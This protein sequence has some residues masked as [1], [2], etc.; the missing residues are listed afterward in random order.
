MLALET[1]PYFRDLDWDTL[2]SFYYVAR[3][4]SMSRA[5]PFLGLDQPSL[6]RRMRK[7]QKHLGYPLLFRHYNG[8]GLTRKGEELL[9]I[10]EN[11]FI[12]MKSF[13]SHPY[14]GQHEK[15]KRKVRIASHHDL[16]TYVLNRFILDYSQKRPDLIFEVIGADHALD[17]ILQ[18]VDIA[19]QPYDPTKEREDADWQI[20]Q[21]PFFT[22]EKKLYASREYLEEYGEPQ[23]V[24]DLKNHRLIAPSI[25]E[26]WPFDDTAWMLES[27]MYQEGERKGDKRKKRD[28]VF[29]SNSLECLFEAAR[30][31]RGII[32]AYDKLATVKSANL[33]NILPDLTIKERQQHFVYPEYLKDDEDIKGIKA[34]LRERMAGLG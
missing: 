15:R 2:K 1:S 10:V 14:A 16:A 13:T 29:L 27:G 12:N 24:G 23:K 34:Y 20:I 18:D 9:V 33:K 31:G 25:P 26:T 6:S 4:G 28:P 22:M 5:A 30:Q 19:I 7:L 32:S 3:V 11:I 17:I 8:I 21:E